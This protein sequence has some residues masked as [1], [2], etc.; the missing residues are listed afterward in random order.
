MGDVYCL[1]TPATH[2]FLLMLN[3]LGQNLTSFSQ[4]IGSDTSCKLTPEEAISMKCQSLFSGKNKK[5]I[6]YRSSTESAQRV[7]K[8]K[9]FGAWFC[10]L[11]FDI[12]YVST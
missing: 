6:I 10:Q 9:I 12:I 2:L 7:V 3:L 11:L 1:Q 5:N 8:I 4:K